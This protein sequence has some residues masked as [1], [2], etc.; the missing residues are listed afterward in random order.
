M[1]G[2]NCVGDFGRWKEGPVLEG[3]N[4][5]PFSRSD[6]ALVGGWKVEKQEEETRA[7]EE[8]KTRGTEK[9]EE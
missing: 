2:Q 4:R 8:R 9:E 7:E 3:E 5:D 6:I 1:P